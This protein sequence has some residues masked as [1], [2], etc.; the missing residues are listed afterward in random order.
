MFH[1]PED[2]TRDQDAAFSAI[3]KRT[4]EMLSD[5]QQL[6]PWEPLRCR[7]DKML[8]SSSLNWVQV[9]CR[10]QSFA[11]FCIILLE[12]VSESSRTVIVVTASVIDNEREDK[13]RTFADLLHQAAT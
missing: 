3:H 4:A 10:S 7:M 2:S 11:L 13:G 8:N 5:A 12:V 9:L 1:S 6:R